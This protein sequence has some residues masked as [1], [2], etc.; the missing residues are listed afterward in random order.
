MMPATAEHQ[1]LAA[2]AELC[3]RQRELVPLVAEALGRAPYDYWILGDGRDDATLDAIERTRDGVW[4]FHFHGLEFDLRHVTDG[5]GVRVDFGP[6][7]SCAF[8]PGGVGAFVQTSKP[9]WR[10]FPTLGEHL[11][12]PLGYDY[13]RCCQLAGALR[14][15][16]LIDHAAPDLVQLMM[17]Y[18]RLTPTGYV[19]EI[20]PGRAP[21]DANALCLCDNLVITERGLQVLRELPDG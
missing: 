6:G 5:R 21:V 7:G 20:P 14:E 16:G 3:T 1:F 9:P 11:V 17:T 19:L 8:T 4:R 18:R 10:S 2:A 12:G 13:A 15:R